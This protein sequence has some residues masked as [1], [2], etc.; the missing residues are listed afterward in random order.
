MPDVPQNPEQILKISADRASAV[1]AELQRLSLDLQQHP[2]A[3]NL[4]QSEGM[5]A[6]SAAIASLQKVASLAESPPKS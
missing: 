1:S 6:L 4:A 5:S 2:V 3:D